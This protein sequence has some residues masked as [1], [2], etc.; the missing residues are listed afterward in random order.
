MSFVLSRAWINK[1]NS[2]S[3]WMRNRTSDLQI[4]LYHWATETPGWARSITKFIWHT[5]CI[6][7]GSVM[8]IAS[9]RIVARNPKVWGSIPYGDSDFFL[10]PTLVKRRWLIY[11][12]NSVDNTKLPYYTLPVPA[13]QFLQ[14]L[15]LFNHLVMFVCSSWIW[16]AEKVVLYLYTNHRA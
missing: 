7:I 12:I 5:S 2:E 9:W 8:S 13:P 6:L 11:V 3:P 16:F 14:K 15:T 10:C 4:H 1:K